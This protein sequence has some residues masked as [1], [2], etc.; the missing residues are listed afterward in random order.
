MLP[1][2]CCSKLNHINTDGQLERDTT[3]IKREN[4]YTSPSLFSLPLPLSL[5]QRERKGGRKD[6]TSSP[7]QSSSK[8]HFILQILPCSPN[9]LTPLM[10]YTNFITFLL[11]LLFVSR[12]CSICPYT[13]LPFSLSPFHLSLVFLFLTY[14]LS[15]MPFLSLCISFTIPYP[16]LTSLLLP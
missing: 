8:S 5:C 9:V 14:T 4:D 10:R 12:C 2:I 7:D 15:F 16:S 11:L 6:L 1:L 13:Y 3:G